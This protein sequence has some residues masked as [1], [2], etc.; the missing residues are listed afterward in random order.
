MELCRELHVENGIFPLNEDKVRAMLRRAFDRQGGI[1]GAIG[2]SGKIEGLIYMLV[3]TFWY[4][5]QPHLEELFAFVVP[6]YRKTKNAIELMKFAKWCS[7][8]SGFPL[9]IGVISN[10]RTEGKI[11]L[12]QRQFSKP[13]GNFFFYKSN[14]K[15]SVSAATSLTLE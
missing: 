2:D 11:R 3:S 13:V 10:E 5:D 15:D 1:I 12:Y 8:R 7:D 9:I 4:S 14:G 6:E